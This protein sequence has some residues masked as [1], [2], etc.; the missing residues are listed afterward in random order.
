MPQDLHTPIQRYFQ[1]NDYN[2]YWIRTWYGNN[3][4]SEADANTQYTRLAEKIFHDD[5][6]SEQMGQQV[7]F[8]DI[9]EFKAD[10]DELQ[11]FQVPGFIFK[12][13]VC[14]PDG[15]N[16]S[17]SYNYN[18]AGRRLYDNVNNREGEEVE[19]I[20]EVERDQVILVFVADQRACLE[21]KV[22]CIGLNQKGQMLPGR[23]RNAA[24]EVAY[25]PG[26]WD[27]GQ[28]L[29]ENFSDDLVDEEID[30][31]PDLDGWDW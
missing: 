12:A 19:D 13:L 10:G 11:P 6:L 3:Q 15:V 28:A 25:M 30:L 31:R 22:L 5:Q 2:T 7:V 1:S 8:D 24:S 27:D 26:N 21:G 17:G 9:A 4:I 18:D 16:R 23:L 14:Y 20:P 29:A